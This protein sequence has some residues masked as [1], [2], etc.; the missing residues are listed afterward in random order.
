MDARNVRNIVFL[1]P[2]NSLIA[3]KQ[4]I[5]RGT[6]LFEGKHY[7]TIV[8]FVNAY[9]MF[10]DPE[11][12]GE[13]AEIISGEE[14]DAPSIGEVS[15]EGGDYKPK[16]MLRIQLSDGNVR[17]LQSTISTYFYFEGNPISVEEFLKKLFNTLQ[18][19]DFFGNE[20]QLRTIWANPVTRRDL[21]QKLEGAGCHKDDLK[22]LQEHINPQDS[23]L[24]DVLVYIAYAKPPVSRA[25]RVE[26]NQAKIYNLLNDK[27]REFVG[28]VLRNYVDKGV[29]ELDDSKLSTVISAKYG[30][31]H[32]ARQE[33]GTVEDIR[34]TFVDFQQHLYQ[35]AVG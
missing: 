9:H 33:L 14:G 24:F 13:P 31:T 15:D 16:P 7:F 18:L 25:A 3:F 11:W 2:I 5:G 17:E 34:R 26:T 29:D 6:R 32:E 12:D 19:P 21:L 28:Y 20:E 8:D 27:Q 30:S 35:E 10:N 4:I 22:K 1:R 23:D